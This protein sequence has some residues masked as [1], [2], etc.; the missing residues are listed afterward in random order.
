MQMETIFL[1]LHTSYST[2]KSITLHLLHSCAFIPALFLYFLQAHTHT[3][4]NEKLYP[5]VS[6][7]KALYFTPA[8]HSLPSVSTFVVDG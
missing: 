5:I 4:F 7:C 3:F 8:F 6:E 1:E 2:V